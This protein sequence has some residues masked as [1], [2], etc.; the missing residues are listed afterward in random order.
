MT[1]PN[2]ENREPEAPVI[3]SA[4]EPSEE[5]EVSTV[6]ITPEAVDEVVDAL[7]ASDEHKVRELVAAMHFSDAADLVERLT[8]EHRRT[9][10]NAAQDVLDPAFF[11]ELDET[12]R[13]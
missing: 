6:G 2:L 11:T 1:D 9:L 7:E 8:T 13:E 5:T 12:I 10:L 4:I 3:P